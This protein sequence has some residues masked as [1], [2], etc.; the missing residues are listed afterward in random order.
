MLYAY[1]VPDMQSPHGFL[2]ARSLWTFA[3]YYDL[4]WTSPEQFIQALGYIVNNLSHKGACRV[5][6]EVSLYISCVLCAVCVC[7]CSC[8]V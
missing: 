6:S 2:R 5:L 3:Q 4:Q 7:V 8:V 1:V